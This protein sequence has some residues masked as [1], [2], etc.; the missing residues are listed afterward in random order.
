MT[1]LPNGKNYDLEERT[2]KFGED[3][4]KFCKGMPRNELTRRII[5][6]LVGC[7]TSVG[8]TIVKLIMPKVPETLNIRLDYVKRN[9]ERLS[10]FY[11]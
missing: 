5:D 11:G 6:Q 2:V 9:P 3:V 4:I 10:I 8:Q 1:Q 7:A